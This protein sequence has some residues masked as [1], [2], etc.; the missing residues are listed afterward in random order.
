MGSTPN[1]VEN[2]FLRDIEVAALD[3]N[4]QAVVLEVA[5]AVCSPLDK[6]HLAVKR[7][8]RYE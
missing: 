5:K 3:E 8:V 6:L 2:V 4:A 7:D 1:I